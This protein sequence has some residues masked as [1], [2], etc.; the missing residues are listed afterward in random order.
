MRPYV[1]E[2]SYPPGVVW[3]APLE[4][5]T[6]PGLLARAA[7]AFGSRPF[8]DFH[9][10]RWTLAEF[11]ERVERLAGGLHRLGVG[12]GVV[13]GL[14][15]PNLPH[16]AVAL[17]A[18]LRAGGC[19]VNLSP[20]D[21]ERV[22][23]AKLADTETEMVVTIAASGFLTKLAR[24]RSEGRPRCIVV[25]REWDFA[26][27]PGESAWQAWGLADDPMP[28]DGVHVA[29]AD[30]LDGG[31][32]PMPALGPSDLALLQY[33]GGTTGVP[34][35]AM[36]THGNLTAAAATYR[37]WAG[38]ARAPLLEGRERMLLVL[39]L[40]HIYALTVGLLRSVLMGFEL[41][42][43]PRFDVERVVQDLRARRP[44]IFAGVPTMFAALA[45]HEAADPAL[46]ACLKQC[47]SGGAPLPL[48]L[49]RTF[50]ARSG[51]VLRDGW[52][53]T[54]TGA[55]G[56]SSPATGSP[57]GAA[58]LPLPGLVV[59]I[60][61]PDDPGRL[62]PVGSRGE[63][64]VRGPSLF[65]GYWK[66]P[67]ATRD[68][69]CDGRFLT[70]DIGVFDERGFLYL[71]DRKKDMIIS[72][73]YNVYPRTIEEAIAEHPAVAEVLVIGVDDAYRG[74]AAKAFV[75]LRPGAAAPALDELRAFL[76]S[77]VGRHELPAAL[78]IRDSLPK[79][80]VGKLW[81]RAL[82]EE[83]ARR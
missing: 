27:A 29:L 54:E 32:A 62:L 52:G 5:G 44:T 28:D 41:L 37:A 38:D 31:P 40:F 59:E 10:T 82:I 60:V 70:G 30:L 80:P 47:G 53:M 25:G 18:V 11:A 48:D 15:L 7:A 63:I 1:W 56:S 23:A 36:L 46:F 34:K 75:A 83:I 33:T 69:F 2:Q 16:Y 58:G 79:T 49:R 66:Q 39:P 22:L 3:D 55:P 51:L 24:A 9:H 77:R 26:A 13:V 12:P 42:L 65:A 64:A 81:K 76:A 43:R 35:A 14:L 19:V 17:F 8:L 50:E 21:A 61:D 4:V 57:P 45:A 6:V 73:G 68:A 74:Q 20:L 72:G 71:V 78:E 67:D